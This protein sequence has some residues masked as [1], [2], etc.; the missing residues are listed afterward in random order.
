MKFTTLMLGVAMMLG[1]QHASAERVSSFGKGYAGI[2]VRTPSFVQGAP[3][4]PVEVQIDY[5]AS[6]AS[7]AIE[8]AYA[9]EGSLALKSPARKQLSPDSNGVSHDKVVVQANLTGA[10]FLNVFVKTSRG[11]DAISIPITVGSATLKPQ[12]ASSVGVPNGQRVIEMPAEVTV[13]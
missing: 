6:H 10:Y 1:F 4:N 3:G 9:T 13:R 7:G 5:I 12:A 2:E 11:G 8:V